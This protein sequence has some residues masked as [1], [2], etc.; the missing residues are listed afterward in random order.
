MADRLNEAGA[1]IIGVAD[2]SAALFDEEG[3]PIS[4]L[5]EFKRDGGRLSSRRASGSI[6][7]LSLD[8]LLSRPCDVLVPAATGHMIHADNV[9][10]LQAGIVI[11]L[12]NMPV[13]HEADAYLTEHGIRVVPDVLA[14]AGGVTVSYLEW[15]QNRMRYNWARERIADELKDRMKEAATAVAERAQRLDCSLRMAAHQIALERMAQASV[16]PDSL[17]IDRNKSK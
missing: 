7:N 12:A 8:E 10:Q 5:I 6:E 3:L 11:E 4:E 14:N 9:E 16:H 15:V 2:S 1:R 13:T 17:L